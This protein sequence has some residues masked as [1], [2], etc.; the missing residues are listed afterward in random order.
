MKD[1][2]ADLSNVKCLGYEPTISTDGGL[3]KTAQWF[4]ENRG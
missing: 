2:L 4:F 1:S 3:S